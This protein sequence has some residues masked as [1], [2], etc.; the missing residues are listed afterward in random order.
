ML[1]VLVTPVLLVLLFWFL[2]ATVVQ[3]LFLLPQL[4]Q[5]L[6]RMET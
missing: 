6:E 2:M 5:V 3:V 4:G 1:L